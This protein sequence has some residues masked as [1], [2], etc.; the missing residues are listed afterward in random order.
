MGFILPLDFGIV[1]AHVM[2]SAYPSPVSIPFI[3]TLGLKTMISV[4]P[5]D[6]RA[7]LRDYC[8]ANDII[9]LEYDVG[10]NQ[11]PFLSMSEA[12]VRN[13]VE[14]ALD[15]ANHP[16]LIFDTNGKNKISCIVGCIEKALGW[17]YASIFQE[18]EQFAGSEA[19]V[20]DTQF[21]E[22]FQPAKC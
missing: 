8:K 12:K 16:T 22:C 18:Y 6:I 17:S 4:S 14:C 7:E 21:I 2:R 15:P 19:S 13:A 10:Y 9:L 3:S 1:T 5:S 11:E 20:L